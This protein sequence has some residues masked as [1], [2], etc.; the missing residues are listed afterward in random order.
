MIAN[1]DSCRRLARL[2]QSLGADLPT[3]LARPL[4]A[5]DTIQRRRG[6]RHASTGLTELIKA[7]DALDDDAIDALIDRTAQDYARGQ[8]SRQISEEAE[9]ICLNTFRDNLMGDGGDQ[10]TERLRPAF[11]AACADLA[12]VMAHCPPSSSAAHA[13]DAGP[14]AVA[15]WQLGADVSR[16]FQ[17]FTQYAV[18]VGR[19]FDTVGMGVTFAHPAA[20]QVAFLIAPGQDLGTAARAFTSDAS[21]YRGGQF[22]ALVANGHASLNLNSPRVAQA[23]CTG[24]SELIEAAEAQG[25]DALENHDPEAAARRAAQVA[26]IR[27]FLGA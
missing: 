27:T 12:T 26:G 25:R 22:H 5:Y 24:Y 13:I 9:T 23:A 18:L 17:T 7:G 4:E 3:S 15:A 6:R 1:I 21:D 11:N 10:L 20:P 8:I 16:R 19:D 14:E 2:A